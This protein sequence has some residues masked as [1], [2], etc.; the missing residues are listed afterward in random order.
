MQ[1][2]INF[3]GSSLVPPP[4]FIGSVVISVLLFFALIFLLIHFRDRS[5]SLSHKLKD[6]LFWSVLVI[7]CGGALLGS[8]FLPAPEVVNVSPIGGASTVEPKGTVVSISFDRPVNR[9]Q[10]E[11]SITPDVP[12]V[13]VFEEPLYGTHLYQKLSFYPDTTL[14]AGV[15][16]RVKLNGVKNTLQTSKP[17]DYEFLFSTREDAK[18]AEEVK[19]VEAKTVKLAVPVHL[20]QHTLSCEVASLKMA[21]AFRNVS[22]TEEEL[23]S[24]VGVDNTPHVGGVWG[25]PYELFVGNVDGN[26]MKDGYGVYWGPIERV[27]KNYVDAK[28]FEGGS[29]SAVTAELDAGNPV[30]LWTYSKNGTPTS[31]KTPSG[32]EIYA[33][34]GQ[35]AVVLVGYV[36]LPSNPEQLIIN[37]PL[38]GQIYWSRTTFDKK[39]ASF[40]ESGVVVYK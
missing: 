15:E 32:Q 30:I 21:L 1:Y 22:K 37:D 38:V 5:L 39:W 35:H 25:N 16:Y 12:G 8:I 9:R 24:Q 23:L 31:W 34:A 10:M 4:V 6:F 27:A 3:A 28:A 29:V 2:N 11:K 13:W 14:N 40:N 19:E 33:V 7:L 18:V 26:Q 20:Q 36:G 17:F